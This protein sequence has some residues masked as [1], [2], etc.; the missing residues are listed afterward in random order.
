MRIAL[1]VIMLFFLAVLPAAAQE[2]QPRVT[3]EPT[4]ET[5]LKQTLSSL[6]YAAGKE[7]VVNGKLEGTTLPIITNRT[8]EEAL[9]ALAEANNFEYV[10]K[11]NMILV[12]PVGGML[13]QTKTFTVRYADL[14][15]LKDQI[16]TIVPAEKIAF[17]TEYQTLTVTATTGQLQRVNQVV[18]SVDKPIKQ[19][20]I[21]VQVVEMNRTE[22]EKLGLK[23]TT[24]TFDSSVDHWKPHYTVTFDAETIIT[25]G[26]V[27]A[28]PEINTANG[29]KAHFLMGEKQPVLMR[30]QN[31]SSNDA[32]ST[33]TVEYKDV[34][35]S[36]DAVARVA[37]DSNVVSMELKPSLSSITGYVTN[38]DTKA[39]V[40][41]TREANTSAL[42]KSGGTIIIAGLIR[43]E[44]IRNSTE[45][46]GLSKI[47]IIGALFKAKD[48]KTYQ[49]EI[50][51]FV[52]PT[53][54]PD[55]EENT[56]AFTPELLPNPEP[57]AGTEGKMPA[58][59]QPAPGANATEEKTPA[60]PAAS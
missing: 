27:L 58:K 45:V 44:D 55:P 26:K 12:G 43:E 51:I 2:D 7:L 19:I 9:E 48:D 36:L 20:N 4:R 15:M 17:N 32:Y 28:R 40:I 30:T 49:S 46:P 16:A 33:T 1:L 56:P 5:S 11:N 14:K 34:G 21:K 25:K 54:L 10:I 18:G 57:V 3:F 37:A 59:I 42:V 52:T 41:S 50:F 24:P 23:Y 6:A 53:I 8:L 38:S 13:T 39:P 22:A 47:P 60:L 35:I 31:G 29:K